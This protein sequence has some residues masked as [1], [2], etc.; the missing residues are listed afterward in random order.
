[1][2]LVDF[3]FANAARKECILALKTVPVSKCLD[4]K[5]LLFGFEIPDLLAIFLT[6]SILNFLFGNTPLKLALVW[7]PTAGLAAALR[8]GKRGKPDNY[9]VHWLRFQIKPGTLSAFHEPTL[10]NAPPRLNRRCA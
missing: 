4:K 6:L 5:L 10:W 8:Y 1:V 9:L 2:A 7:L 3:K